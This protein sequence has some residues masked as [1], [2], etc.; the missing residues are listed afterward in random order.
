VKIVDVNLLV[1]ATMQRM[2]GHT[3]AR[4]WMESALAETGTLALG[5][6]A[7]FGYVRVVTNR[8]V[9]DPPRSVDGAL[10]DVES[11]LDAG[12]VMVTPGPRHL[13][14]AFKLLRARGTAA[15][16]TTDVQLAALAIENQAELCSADTDFARFKGLRWVNPLADE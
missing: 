6:V 16:L 2:P 8:R 1:H 15:N 11:W 7:L 13:D 5:H 9:F 4:G 3:K 12:A 10:A 14:I